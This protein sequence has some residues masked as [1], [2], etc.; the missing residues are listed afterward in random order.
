MDSVK[1]IYVKFEE[2][3]MNLS[4]KESFYHIFAQILSFI[5]T[6]LYYEL[7][8]SMTLNNM[9]M[10]SL[11]KLFKV[12]ISDFYVTKI[13]KIKIEFQN[14]F[15]RD[16]L[17]LY[18]W[19]PHNKKEQKDVKSYKML[20]DKASTAYSKM[21]STRKWFKLIGIVIS[22]YFAAKRSLCLSDTIF[23]I[24]FTLF[25]I[26]NVVMLKRKHKEI[27]KIFN[28]KNKRLNSL[29]SL[30]IPFY[31]YCHDS[32]LVELY[33]E[34]ISTKYDDNN[35]EYLRFENKLNNTKMIILI[36]IKDKLMYS[37]IISKIES[38]IGLFYSYYIEKD[39]YLHDIKEYEDFVEDTKSKLITQK[40]ILPE[41]INN[42]EI[43]DKII[44]TGKSGC[45]K[46]TFLRKICE[47]YQ[48]YSH[49]IVNYAQGNATKMNFT[50]VSIMDI[51]KNKSKETITK[52]CKI[53]KINHI[54]EKL[55][56][57]K[58]IKMGMSGGEKER[59]T[60]AVH[61]SKLEEKRILLLDEPCREIDSHLAYEIL[62]NI[63]SEY[64][65][66]LIIII[67][68]LERAKEKIKYKRL[69]DMD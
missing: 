28:E 46:T 62:N 57:D 52:V 27:N 39:T 15:S 59:L 16:A 65:D 43:D 61:L 63:I 13:Q 38:L 3:Y 14:R 35:T 68:H 4:D 33:E 49:L 56:W 18:L 8:K 36:W 7:S 25:S 48:E 24:L 20:V 32:N 10:L 47:N 2:Y 69:V 42:F 11:F 21:Q 40:D 5:E 41:K 30:E 34:K 51:F 1:K 58:V 6:C 31:R 12:I 55:G 60:L 26:L 22:L 9:L 23:I 53:A 45:G 50:N 17:K 67:S 37:N 29:I 44:I 54:R 19:L 64:S 66:R